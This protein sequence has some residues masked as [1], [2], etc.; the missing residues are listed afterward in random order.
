MKLVAW[1]IRIILFALLFVLALRNTAEVSLQ[2]FFDAVWQAPLILILLAA[3]LLGAVAAIAAVAPR[4]MRQRIEIA[5][6]R[7][8]AGAARVEPVAPAGTT[9]AATPYNV[10]GP[11]V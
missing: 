5:R 9:G 10:I 1:I 7:R 8:A 3:F 2:L 6:L 11:K 4:L